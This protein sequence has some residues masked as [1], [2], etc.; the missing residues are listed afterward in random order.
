[1]NKRI[2]GFNCKTCGR[3]FATYQALGGHRT[4]HTRLTKLVE[5]KKIKKEFHRCSICGIYFSMG[6]AL[7]GHMRRHKDRAKE[8]FLSSCWAE[9][10]VTRK[11]TIGLNLDLN[12]IPMEED[13]D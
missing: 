13:E 5:T 11:S 2:G 6:Q 1:M 8:L 3:S 10:R 9:E 12:S 7:G 4:A